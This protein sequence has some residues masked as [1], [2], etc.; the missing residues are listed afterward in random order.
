MNVFKKEVSYNAMQ[1]L[2][3]SALANNIKPG[4]HANLKWVR[5][6]SDEADSS[7]VVHEFEGVNGTAISF[8]DDF[9]NTGTGFDNCYIITEAGIDTANQYILC[10]LDGM[11]IDDSSINLLPVEAIWKNNELKK[12]GSNYHFEP[13]SKILSA[14]GK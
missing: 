6:Y 13:E 8:E 3:F 5:S 10:N 2:A 14:S 4:C 9:I 7:I 12:K 1:S 11:P